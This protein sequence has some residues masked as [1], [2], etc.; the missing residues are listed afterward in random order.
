MC[1][2]SLFCSGTLFLSISLNKLVIPVHPSVFMVLKLFQAL[3]NITF[4]F[5]NQ[6]FYTCQQLKAIHNSILSIQ[7]SHLPTSTATATTKA[8]ATK[9]TKTSTA[10]GATGK[11]TATKCA[12]PK[13]RSTKSTTCTVT[14]ATTTTANQNY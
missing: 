1:D 9:S 7:N 3:H 6:L 8:T 5:I 11:S 10:S 2:K 14:T 4:Q 12:T 13:Y